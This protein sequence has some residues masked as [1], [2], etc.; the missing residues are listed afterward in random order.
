MDCSYIF[1]LL[2]STL[3]LFV[4]ETLRDQE[5]VCVHSKVDLLY[6]DWDETTD[7]SSVPC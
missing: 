4:P 3:G 7:F 5:E 1:F 2:F 6:S